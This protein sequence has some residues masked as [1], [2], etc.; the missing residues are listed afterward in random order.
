MVKARIRFDG[1]KQTQKKR[2]TVSEIV[3]KKE[4]YQKSPDYRV[5]A[6]LEATCQRIVEVQ[7][8]YEV[9]QTIVP[10]I[11]NKSDTVKKPQEQCDV[12]VLDDLLGINTFFNELKNY[13]G[14]CSVSNS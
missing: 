13:K 9:T 11:Q 5:L 3:K 8:P 4:Q 2:I 6:L 12:E 10:H 14:S 7:K 1:G